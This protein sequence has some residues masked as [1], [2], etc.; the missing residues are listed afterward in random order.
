[1]A[2]VAFKE[3]K[4]LGETYISVV[5]DGTFSCKVLSNE[6]GVLVVEHFATSTSPFDAIRA[7]CDCFNDL[8]EN[9]GVNKI[10]VTLGHVPMAITA[11]NAKKPEEMYLYW[12]DKMA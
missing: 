9:Y 11:E 3:R 12:K 2:K 4:G 1:M 10:K 8:A 7:M 6:D 5:F